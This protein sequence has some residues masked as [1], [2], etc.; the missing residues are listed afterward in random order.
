MKFLMLLNSNDVESNEINVTTSTPVVV[1][2][3]YVEPDACRTE[4]GNDTVAEPVVFIL[5]LIV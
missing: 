1:V 3:T 2:G 4:E 5:R